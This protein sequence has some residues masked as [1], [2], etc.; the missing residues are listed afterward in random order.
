MSEILSCASEPIAALHHLVLRHQP[1]SYARMTESG[2]RAKYLR[3][4]QPLT[5]SALAA[6]LAGDTTLA[7]V[8]HT[9]GMSFVAAC[10]IDEGGEAM[11]RAVMRAAE[12]RACH[13]YGFVLDSGG[14]NGGHVWVFFEHAH[15][16]QDLQALMRDIVS[17]AQCPTT[18]IYPN[19]ADLRL[20]FGLHRRCNRRGTLLLNSAA[21][22]VDLD[23]DFD[24]ALATF[25]AHV[26]LTSDLPVRVAQDTQ[27][28]RRE[29]VAQAIAAARPRRCDGDAHW[30]EVIAHFNSSTDLVS[31]LEGYGARAAYHYAGGKTLL[32]CA[33]TQDHAHGDAHPS[34]VVEPG[35][36]H[37]AG[38]MICGCYCPACRLHNQPGQVMDAFEV[39]CRLEGIS[40]REGVQRIQKGD[41]RQTIS[42]PH[43][44]QQRQVSTYAE[45]SHASPAPSRSAPPVSAPPAAELLLQQRLVEIHTDPRVQPLDRR[46][47]AYV[48]SHGAQGQGI[49]NAALAAALGARADSIK[50]AK[51]RLRELGYIDVQISTDGQSASVITILVS[52]NETSAAGGVQQAPP[53]HVSE[54]T[55]VDATPPPESSNGAFGDVPII[56][57]SSD[58]EQAQAALPDVASLRKLRRRRGVL[59]GMLSTGV[60]ERRR[61]AFMAELATIEATLAQCTEHPQPQ[62]QSQ[63]AQFHQEVIEGV[64]TQDDTRLAR[65]QDAHPPLSDA[66][67]SAVLRDTVQESLPAA[68]V[69]LLGRIS[70]H[71]RESDIVVVCGPRD[72]A[73]AREHLLLVS[74]R[75]LRDI[76]LEGMACRVTAQIGQ[77]EPVEL[78]PAWIDA[79]S[80]IQVP[81]WLRSS[82]VGSV[83]VDGCL[84]GA[85]PVST[86]RLAQYSEIVCWL[87]KT[88]TNL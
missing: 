52:Q 31:L 35:R 50:R 3:I 5:D 66:R 33:S 37:Q 41:A 13:A 69:P 62:G 56:E 6:H 39:F 88:I 14:H 24:G 20:P 25:L 55:C 15:T 85:T 72:L 18:E 57:V 46:L 75:A 45:T 12:V 64:V 44:P 30:R 9:D 61:Y 42:S 19:G 65:P 36:G 11:V 83:L 78:Q 59:L 58:E 80:W 7:C 34:L 79:D 81:Y 29:A 38:R 87:L 32:H 22:A 17:D 70:W 10:D 73:A 76:G 84:Y 16:T 82:L 60:E 63:Q 67:L 27:R 74:Q 77:P 47:L 54:P 53:F 49:A 23:S 26:R 43:P 4:S 51:R 2:Y 86:A 71:Q 21:V 1:S 40:K 28:A 68:L 8:L 48:I